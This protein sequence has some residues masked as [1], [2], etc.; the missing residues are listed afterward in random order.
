MSVSSVVAV[1]VSN[2][3]KQHKK[4]YQWLA[5]ELGVSKSLVQHMINGDRTF[6]SERIFQV[7]EVLDVSV[8]ELIDKKSPSKEYTVQLRG[9]ITTREGES[10]LQNVIFSCFKDDEIYYANEIFNKGIKG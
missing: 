3:L 2:W 6:T 5:D 10:A 1:Y 9:K 4:S 8:D 7:S